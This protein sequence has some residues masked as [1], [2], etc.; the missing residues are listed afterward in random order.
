VT[1]PLA[2]GGILAAGPIALLLYGRPAGGAAVTDIGAFAAIGMASLPAQGIAS[3]AQSYL[4][5]RRR[6]GLL[7]AINGLG[8]AGYVIVGA[9]LVRAFGTGVVMLGYIAVHWSVALALLAAA[10]RVGAPLGTPVVRDMGIALVLASAA[11]AVFWLAATLLSASSLVTF[12]IAAIGALA[13]LAI[14]LVP[15]YRSLDG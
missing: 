15:R 1:V 14:S 12:V 6:L 3:V 7:L 13:A 10:S 11:F 2:L 4:I 8:V 9:A 5:A